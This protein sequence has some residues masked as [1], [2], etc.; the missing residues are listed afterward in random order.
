MP[1]PTVI[2]DANAFKAPCRL[3]PWFSKKGEDRIITMVDNEENYERIIKTMPHACEALEGGPVKAYL[4]IDR[5]V[6]ISEVFS[7]CGRDG[8]TRYFEKGEKSL[9]TT[10]KEEIARIGLFKGRNFYAMT[11]ESRLIRATKGDM[12]KVSWRIVFPDLIIPS[13]SM[14]GTYLKAIGYKNDQPFDLSVYGKGRI[15]NAAGCVKPNTA[16]DDP[17]PPLN[18]LLDWGGK[19]EDRLITA[20]DPDLPVVDIEIWMPKAEEV[21]EPKTPPSL[22]VVVTAGVADA[23]DVQ[24]LLSIISPDCSY[25]RWFKILCAISNTLGKDG[26]GVYE[27][28]DDWSALGKSYDARAFGKTWSSIKEKGTLSIATLHYLAKEE[29]ATRY[30]ELFPKGS[31]KGNKVDIYKSRDYADIKATFE[32]TVF[33]VIKPVTFYQ[34]KSDGSGY[35][36]A[37][38]DKIKAAYRNVIYEK[39]GEEQA[40]VDKKKQKPAPL[41]FINSWLKDPTMR[42]YD[43]TEFD[44]SSTTGEDVFNTFTGFAAERIPAV[45]DEEVEELVKPFEDHMKMLIGEEGAKYV[46]MWL[47]NMVQNPTNKASVAIV[48]HSDGEGTGKSLPFKSFGDKVIG[49]DWYKPT[50]DPVHDLFDKHSNGIENKLLVQVEEARGADLVKNM[51]RMKDLIT[52][53]RGRLERKGVDA[54]DINN[55]ASFVFTTNNDNPIKISP[56]DRR[57]VAFDCNDV[58]RGDGDY[59]AK[60]VDLMDKPE[61]ARAM[62]QYLKEMED[63]PRN[64][65]LVR[66]I[67]NYYKEIQRINIP[68]WAKYLAVKSLVVETEYQASDFYRSYTYWAEANGYGQT[69][70]SQTGFALK[71]KKIDGITKVKNDVMIYKMDW[72]KVMAFMKANNLWDEEAF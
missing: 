9:L 45:A 68:N 39:A 22:D 10:I 66:P 62:Y 6:P 2:V 36:I 16:G 32:E 52:N 44:P 15:M 18:P 26:D 3:T 35:F 21:A 65:Q 42:A 56:T 5:K 11:R 61:W 55:Y 34:K 51:D 1:A 67:T 29:N 60:L 17:C 43:R 71:V 25:E 30:G 48:L 7:A 37:T 53:D 20:V 40:E 28:A 72:V 27:M 63:L 49:R 41:S 19:L 46:M 31:R 8:I 38:E 12:V 47:A 70:L 50:G 24:K 54:Y 59:F 13:H 57:F 14:L 64:F 69:K 58:R 4:D 23:S 33:K